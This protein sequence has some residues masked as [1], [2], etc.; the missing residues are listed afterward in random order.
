MVDPPLSIAHVLDITADEAAVQYESRLA[1]D[2]RESARKSAP[3]F[4]VLGCSED[5]LY[6]PEDGELEG[7]VAG[8]ME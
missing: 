5:I 3:S 4:R 7:G 2:I 8:R 1:I 6:G